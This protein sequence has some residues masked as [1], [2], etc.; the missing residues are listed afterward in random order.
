M[1][2]GERI[3]Q[4]IKGRPMDM[5]KFPS[6]ILAISFLLFSAGCQNRQA[7]P[8]PPVAN[9]EVTMVTQ[10]DV[11]LYS[12]WVTTLDGYVN[13]NI[14]PQVSGYLVA[15]IYKEGFFVHKG[16]VL[17]KI[18]PRPFKVAL[19]KAQG[20][21]AQAQAQLGKSTED[22]DRDTPLAQVKAIAQSQLD[23]DIQAKLSAQAAEASARADVDQ[24]QLNLD[25]TEVKSLIGG[26]A[27]IAKGQIGD[28]VGPNTLL[29]T[30]SQLDPI[31][32]YV[33]MTESEYF[34]YTH[35]SSQD[36][37]APTL[38][39]GNG[40][41]Y[42]SKGD[43]IFADRQIDIGTGTILVAVSFPN[44]GN[45]LRPGQFGRVRAAMSIKK[46]ALLVPQRAVMEIQGSDQVAVVGDDNKV[47]IKSVKVGET[48]GS[49]WVIDEGLQPGERVVVEGIQNI[50]DG[51]VVNPTVVDSSHKGS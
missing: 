7:L 19:E 15:Q 9:V 20:E 11:P 34:R 33:S 14:Q 31:K 5:L 22:V 30:V 26:I 2:D 37:L 51:V 13:A 21:L 23:D 29:T 41:T 12:E 1:I 44:P 24:A 27:G 3:V 16:D 4:P 8:P 50:K 46:N 42:P 39:L 36:D 6:F 32:A 48:I 45:V 28:L 10:Q 40:E 18:D 47:S 43:F 38:T 35:A 49:R 25:F 17:F